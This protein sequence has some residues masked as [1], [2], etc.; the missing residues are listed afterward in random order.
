M[1]AIPN[2][3]AVSVSHLLSKG[4]AHLSRPLNTE[5]PSTLGHCKSPT[6]AQTAQQPALQGPASVLSQRDE[7]HAD[8]R[9]GRE[10][11]LPTDD[12]PTSVEALRSPQEG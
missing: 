12:A 8:W 1:F 6:E 4:K 2:T 7:R 5:S 9:R 3:S 11:S 10:G